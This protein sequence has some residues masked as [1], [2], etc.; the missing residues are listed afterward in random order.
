MNLY[1]S[2]FLCLDIGTYGVRGF[3]HHVRNAK[4][5]Q[6]ATHFVKNT[7]TIYA[8]KMVV[9]ELEQQLNTH[10]DSAF[11][12][13]NFGE[14]DFKTVSNTISWNGEH[15]ISEFDLKHQIAKITTP[16]DFYAMHIIPIFYGTP[17]IKNIKNTPIGHI[18]TQLKSI[19]SI[20]SYEEDKTKY[21]SDILRRTH[22]QS[23]GF[24]DSSFVQNEIYRH[25]KERVLFIDFGAEYTTVSIWTDR[26]PL[27]FEKI[28]IGQHDIT[29][30]L[31]HKLEISIDDADELKILVSNALP[32]EMDRFTPASSSEKFS[33]FSRADIN[34]VF[35]PELK[36]II[37]NVYDHAKKYIEQYKPEKIILTG[38]GTA[39]ANIDTF[40][41]QI[42][43]LPVDNQT[44]TAT[45]NALAE[46]IW[47]LRLPERNAYLER[48]EKIQNRLKKITN[49]F[50]RNKKQKKKKFIPILPSTLCFDMNDYTTYTMFASAG[51]SMIHVD[52][53]DGF[54]VD[55]IAGSITELS[56]IRSKTKSHLHVHL[57][58]ESPAIWAS[59]AIN[60]GAD[61]VIISTNTSGVHDAINVIK[62]AG[63]RC[64]I[65]LNP[66]S[67]VEIL[68]PILKEIDEIMIMAV[69]PGAAGQEFDTRVLQKIKMLDYTRKKHGLKYLISVDGGIKP[70][71]AKLCWSAGANLLVS[72]SY[73][74]NAEDFPLA[75][76]SL[77]KH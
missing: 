65:A 22:I 10:F 74:A 69:N 47:Q 25:E 64:G 31:A 60:A 66:E 20:I 2:Y 36:I 11:I 58:T 76:Q 33:K 42:F 59:D 13:G 17:N 1:N 55:R 15:K 57:M 72:G 45:I 43:K 7:N 73:L 26:G 34:E 54:Y 37:N 44:E 9:D 46:Y 27:Y 75:V 61:T 23:A 53:M 6:S 62:K 51:I 49:V 50:S 67:N 4:I 63:K 71:T 30:A 52:I 21:I 40:I 18:S 16:D 29:N 48:Q 41:E 14:S 77:L 28:K 5:V 38:G 32:N 24:F 35:I 56:E 3:A 68:I 39:I 12:T 70:E 19:Y 8:L